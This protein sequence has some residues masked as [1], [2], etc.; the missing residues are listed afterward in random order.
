[1]L[2]KIGNDEKIAGKPHFLDGFQLCAQTPG[3][4]F[5]YR[6]LIFRVIFHDRGHELLKSFSR[7]A[8]KVIIECFFG[9][10]DLELREIKFPEF[11]AEV[12]ALSYQYSVVDR[13]GRRRKKRLHFFGRTH[14]KLV[15]RHAHP[16]FVVDRFTGLDAQKNVVCLRVFGIEVVTVVGG[17]KR[18][19]QLTAELN[20][21]LVG[22][23][24]LRQTVLHNLQEKIFTAKNLQILKGG[25]A[26]RIHIAV[27]NMRGD[28]SMQT[29]A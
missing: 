21:P 4:S 14:V 5:S 25:L 9:I 17:D 27:N 15:R 11:Q 24:L 7:L 2:Y 3:I 12:A 19:R 26:C 23:L 20:K 28:L 10:F 13:L 1:M 29:R 22:Y 8:I 18:D 16:V 6:G